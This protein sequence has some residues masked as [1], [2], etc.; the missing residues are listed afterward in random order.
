[1]PICQATKRNNTPCR[2]HTISNSK[3]CYFHDPARREQRRQTQS[4]GGHGRKQHVLPT[5]SLPGDLGLDDR[6]AIVKTLAYT[7]KAVLGGQI[8]PKAGNTVAYLADCALRAL[9]SGTDVERLE[10]LEGQQQAESVS[11]G[12]TYP[13]DCAETE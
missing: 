11:H 8:D 7:A 9:Q 1:M 3:F 5:M 4:K 2:N 10:R 13:N 12:S 6:R